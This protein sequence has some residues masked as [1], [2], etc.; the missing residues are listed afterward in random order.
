MRKIIL[1][2]EIHIYLLFLL[3]RGF[4]QKRYFLFLMCIS[5][6]LLAISQSTLNSNDFKK[7]D[8]FL[9]I[10]TDS[11]LQLAKKNKRMAPKQANSFAR[12]ALEKASTEGDKLLTA[13]SQIMMGEIALYAM[14]EDS[15]NYYFAK[16][17][18]NYQ[19]IN[20]FVGL[21]EINIHRSSFYASTRQY[22]KSLDFAFK[23]L[24]LAEESKEQKEIAKAKSKVGYVHFTLRDLEKA[25]KYLKEAE[26]IQSSSGFYKDLLVTLNNLSKTY[27]ELKDYDQAESNN[28]KSINYHKKYLKDD[29]RSLGH[30][31]NLRGLIFQYG[32]ENH[33]KSHTN[34]KEALR[35]GILNNDRINLP[36]YYLNLANATFNIGKPT[37]ALDIYNKGIETSKEVNP[38]D[39]NLRYFY[40]S[41]AYLYEQEGD[42][43]KAFEYTN[44]EKE[45][46]QKDFKG[47]IE[48][49]ESELEIKYDAGKKDETI[50]IQEA[51]ISQQNQIQW[52]WISLAGLLTLLLG[53]LFLFF[54]K[55]KKTN[56]L[57][58]K[59]NEQNELLLKEIHH[60]VKNNLETIS[61]LLLL[62]TAHI[63]D[64]KVLD[65]V[66]QSQNRV[67]SMALIHQKLYQGENLAAIEMKDYF[68]NLVE[69][70]IDTFGVD[71][72]Q[73]QINYEMD[74]IE[75]D[76]DSAIPL[77]LIANE[78]LTNSLKYAFP[79]NKKG[80]IQV[81]LK[82]L[83][84]QEFSF[85]IKDN[86]V[87][88][89][90][91]NTSTKSGFGT[92][93]VNLLTRQLD[94]ILN[95]DPTNGMFTEVRFRI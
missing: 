7:Q 57:L 40:Q 26:A 46:I 78:L 45:E 89:I 32:F 87:G 3:K 65:A 49:L 61:S 13:K 6:S 29:N 37:E 93:L 28:E 35:L 42:F 36:A 44:L 77:G 8:S 66:E 5:F 62:Q 18:K 70:I 33:E 52:M 53:S 72:E 21:I 4:F 1:S 55:N 27:F 95:T 67:Q 82:Q 39:F 59:K 34:Y 54:R 92:Q 16:A 24:E 91:N 85:S 64:Q 68:Q 76:V 71:T 2:K 58:Q 84:K 30:F 50:A 80:K 23:A 43:N 9:Q 60:R 79:K 86:G 81:S 20:D 14:Q 75:M 12:Q 56:A 15:M 63:D 11:L 94:G 25:E 73:I 19:S 10:G 31:Y 83:A 48:S 38:D 22:E 17:E 74:K 51:T 90:P 41:I 69:S 88:F 47:R